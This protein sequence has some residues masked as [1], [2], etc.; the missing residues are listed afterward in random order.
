M[1]CIY[2]VSFNFRGKKYRLL[3]DDGFPVDYF[4]LPQALRDD[5]R[6]QRFVDRTVDQE[7]ETRNGAYD[8]YAKNEEDK[9]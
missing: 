8:F 1:S 4:D 2:S 9:D 5:P 7:R 3:L 6:F